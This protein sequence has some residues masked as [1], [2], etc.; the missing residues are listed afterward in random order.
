MCTNT[1]G[2]LHFLWKK[3]KWLLKQQSIKPKSWPSTPQH[4]KRQVILWNGHQ[5]IQSTTLLGSIPV[6]Y[7]WPITDTQSRVTMVA[8]LETRRS[9]EK[10]LLH[11][12]ALTSMRCDYH[13]IW[14]TT[15]PEFWKKSRR[16]RQDKSAAGGSDALTSGSDM[17]T[18]FL[19]GRGDVEQ[20]GEAQAGRSAAVWAA[21]Q[22]SN[23]T[24]LLLPGTAASDSPSKAK[25]E[26]TTLRGTDRPPSPPVE[27]APPFWQRTNQHGAVWSPLNKTEAPCISTTATE[28]ELTKQFHCTKTFL[29]FTSNAAYALRNYVNPTKINEN[30]IQ[31]E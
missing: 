25:V 29:P 7:H 27:N 18:W 13:K 16:Q 22:W 5:M 2:L 9:T 21:H 14:F 12:W 30:F 31:E 20:H 17:T 3:N 28:R 6:N 1:T 15:E 10:E 11:R 23:Q 24:W 19:G 4:S 8:T 26:C